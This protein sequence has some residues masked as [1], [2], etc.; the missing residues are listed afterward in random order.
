MSSEVILGSICWPIAAPFQVLR[1]EKIPYPFPT[2]ALFEN[3]TEAYCPHL[4]NDN[5]CILKKSYKNKGCCYK[6][7]SGRGC[8][9]DDYHK[10]FLLLNESPNNGGVTH[11]KPFSEE[12][13]SDS[14][15]YKK[16]YSYSDSNT[17]HVPTIL[18]AFP[19]PK[20]DASKLVGL[21]IFKAGLN[22][23]VFFEI[24]DEFISKCFLL[25]PDDLKNLP[26]T[27]I[28][29]AKSEY[30]VLENLK[31]T[32]GSG[33]AF[34]VLV[35]KEKIKEL[36][37]PND[38]NKAKGFADIYLPVG[39]SFF[40]DKKIDAFL[41]LAIRTNVKEETLKTNAKLVRQALGS[42][43]EVIYNQR[44][45]FLEKWCMRLG[46]RVDDICQNNNPGNQDKATKEAMKFALEA[47]LKM[48]SSLAVQHS[49]SKIKS[50][51]NAFNYKTDKKYPEQIFDPIKK[52]IQKRLDGVSPDR[53]KYVINFC[54]KAEM[55]AEEF[56]ASEGKLKGRLSAPNVRE[57]KKIAH[58]SDPVN[59]RILIKGEPGGGK[60]VTAEDFHF[61]CMKRIAEPKN[62]NVKNYIE[63]VE[64]RLKTIFR[65]PANYNTSTA[66]ASANLFFRQISNTGWWLWNQSLKNDDFKEKIDKF[67]TIQHL[68]MQKVDVQ[69][70]LNYF[71][72]I[73]MGMRKN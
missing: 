14:K 41:N 22:D 46:E 33:D 42:M 67:L 45:E 72:K 44:Q 71:E 4:K 60:G 65:L 68:V 21:K 18:N 23:R 10:F 50:I 61:Y 49:R 40:A 27:D 59:A 30:T 12:V 66:G 62:N 58:T 31:N 9:Y 73:M 3:S 51:A 53:K 29:Y 11:L 63:Q 16:L 7:N 19:Q 39:L 52:Y 20:S 64:D 37:P 56:V 34:V 32:N 47:I 28:V 70:E 13:T 35:E 5:N 25:K 43:R 55:Y 1:N 2:S 54:K 57:L 69:T 17:E 6:G 26:K 36:L 8:I 38:I 24:K 15:T 48:A